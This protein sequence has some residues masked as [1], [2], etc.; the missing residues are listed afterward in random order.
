LLGH[1]WGG[2]IAMNAI[3]NLPCNVPNC[4]SQY[5]RP[6]ELLAGTFFG[7]YL[8]DRSGRILPTKNAGI[9]IALI[10]GS[11]DS[12]AKP[13]LVWQSYKNIQTLPKT[14]ML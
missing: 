2:A 11:I 4:T 6:K 5:S 1:S 13:E 12:S 7:S 14:V 10:G 3:Q 9:P 8:K